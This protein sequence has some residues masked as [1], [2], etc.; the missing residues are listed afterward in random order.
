MSGKQRQAHEV[1]QKPQGKGRVRGPAFLPMSVCA[2]GL[3][4]APAWYLGPWGTPPRGRAPALWGPTTDL[5]R[6][7]KRPVCCSETGPGKGCCLRGLKDGTQPLSLLQ[8]VKATVARKGF[9]N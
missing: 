6:L 4:V 3:A 1:P 8:K 7:G 9:L 2:A 5:L